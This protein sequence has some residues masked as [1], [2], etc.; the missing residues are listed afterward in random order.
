MQYRRIGAVTR[1]GEVRVRGEVL[2]D[3]LAPAG[4]HHAAARVQHLDRTHAGDGIGQQL[5]LRRQRLGT[6]LQVGRGQ[7]VA[8]AGQRIADP[9][10]LL[11][12]VRFDRLGL[13]LQQFE[14]A[15]DL[16]FAGA[17]RLHAGQQQHQ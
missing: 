11:H 6:A 12:E 13:A 3:Q 15:R 5:E 10:E 14:I 8:H 17:A 4:R 16:R 1:V 2:A 9:G 7:Q